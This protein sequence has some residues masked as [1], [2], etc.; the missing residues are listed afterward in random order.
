MKFAI[1][2][3]IASSVNAAAVVGKVE[4]MEE[5]SLKADAEADKTCKTE[6]MQDGTTSLMCCGTPLTWDVTKAINEETKVALTPAQQATE[7]AKWDDKV[8]G[9]AKDSGLCL[10]AGKTAITGE[11]KIA[12]TY[13]CV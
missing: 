5:C 6:K 4:G 9:I 11:D 13:K 12:I 3:L 7:K 1:A 10:P 8:K 2:L